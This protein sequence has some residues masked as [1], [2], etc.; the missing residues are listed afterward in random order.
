M[1]TD[2]F[3]IRYISQ[4]HFTLG[5]EIQIMITD[6]IEFIAQQIV[7]HSESQVRSVSSHYMIDVPNLCVKPYTWS[8]YN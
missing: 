2:P 8:L 3:L 6:I 4:T 5:E 1:H 7:Y